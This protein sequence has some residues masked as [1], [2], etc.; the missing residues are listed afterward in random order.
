MNDQPI[1]STPPSGTVSPQRPAIG[2]AL[3]GAAWDL[4]YVGFD[5]VVINVLWALFSLTVIGFPPAT[6]AL[7]TVAG[8]LAY[9]RHTGWRAFFRAARDQFWAGW[10]W[11]IL[12]G[13]A[14]GIVALNIWFYSGIAAR[15][16]GLLGFAWI[17]LLM[18]WI[19]V[20][21]YS[22]PL[23][24]EQERPSVRLAARNALA[25]TVRYPAFTLVHALIAGAIILISLLLPLL[26]A[27]VTAGLLAFLYARA[28]RVLLTA[29][30]GG[31]PDDI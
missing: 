8:D 31:D 10:R 26:W 1:P 3:S 28:V 11:A 21:L 12:N 5:L 20:E 7:F 18:I 25:L 17:G 9:R 24:L 14:I 30:R 19:G 4:L 23:L 2:R 15:W 16:A 29:E 13:V 27:L 22:F 6:A